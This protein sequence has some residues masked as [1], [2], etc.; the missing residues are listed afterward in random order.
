MRRRCQQQERLRD[1]RHALAEFSEFVKREDSSVLPAMGAIA[2]VGTSSAAAELL[3]KTKTDFCRMRSRLHQLGRC[4]QTGGRVPRRR[5][6][7]K[8]RLTTRTSF[9]V[10]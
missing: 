9:R 3:G 8:R 7:Y 5:K 2:T 1:V 10:R 4:F 6:P